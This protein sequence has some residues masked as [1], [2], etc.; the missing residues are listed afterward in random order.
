MSQI[1]PADCGPL[2][3]LII[4]PTPFCNLDCDY[5]YLPDRKNREQIAP[6]T[7]RAILRWTAESGLVRSKFTVVW[8]AGEPLVMPPGFYREAGSLLRDQFPVDVLPVQNIQTNAT[9][10][11]PEWCETIRDE[12]ILLGVSV[13]GPAFLHDRHRKT[14]SGSGTWSK[15]VRGIQLLNEA[16]IPFH[17]ITVLTA[18]SL[19]YPDEL[20]D[21][22]LEN[23]I[24]QLAFNIEEIEGPH[25]ISS[26]RERH[27]ESRLR[28]FLDRFYDLIKDSGECF[29]IREFDSAVGGVLRGGETASSGS[30]QS[31][32]FR[33]VSADCR[34]NLSTFSPEL[35]GIPG[36][37]YGTFTFG[38]VATQRLEDILSMPHFKAI[39]ADI[40]AGVRKC[41]TECPYFGFC[42][43]GAPGN[44]F[45]EN[46]TFDSTETMFCQLERTTTA[47]HEPRGTTSVST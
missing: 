35:L 5:C 18:D 7:L 22:Y 14:R 6:D 17:V 24:R 46:G 45:F 37:Q 19:D 33:I 13:D 42:G 12:K 32:P 4:Q 27:A 40:A 11:T 21:F 8:H 47:V 3:L 29:S 9:L 30:Q 1:S 39:A 34:G 20:F 26:M 25:Q 38:N 2:E 31:S 16:A 36:K 10:L 44:K 43:G 15:V 28:R 41:E 23:N